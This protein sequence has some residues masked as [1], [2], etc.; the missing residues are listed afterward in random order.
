MALI[1]KRQLQNWQKLSGDERDLLIEMLPAT[2]E[3]I[4]ELF[5]Y[6]NDLLGEIDCKHDLEQTIKYAMQK[7]LSVSKLMTWLQEN[8]GFCDCEVLKNVEEE[9]EAVFGER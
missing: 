8:G 5:D 9:W 7:G 6:L 3:Q 4:V 2:K 1:R